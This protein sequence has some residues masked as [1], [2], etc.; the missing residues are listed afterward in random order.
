M[1]A[2]HRLCMETAVAYSRVF[3]PAVGTHGKG[4]HRGL[5]PVVKANRG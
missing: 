5:L 3:P 2:G 1:I 4:G